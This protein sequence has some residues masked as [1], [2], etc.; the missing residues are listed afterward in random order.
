MKIEQVD[1]GVFRG[2]QPVNVEDWLALSKLGIKFT[3]DLETG[4]KLWDDG[5]PLQ[6]ALTSERYGIRTF[7][8]PLGEFL[9][10]N[11]EELNLACSV[12]VGHQP[13][14]IH[15]RAGFNRTGMVAAQYKIKVRGW[16]KSRAVAEMKS[17]GMQ[18]WYFWWAWFL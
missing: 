18:A 16:S 8:H 1:I 7:S 12:I 4:R 13:I 14:Y 11:G 17:M 9:P 6:E 5:Y 3:L 15:C 2:P 10:P